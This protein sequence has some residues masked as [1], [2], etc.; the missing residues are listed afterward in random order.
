MTEKDTDKKFDEFVGNSREFFKRHKIAKSLTSLIFKT[1][2][3]I[4]YGADLS[5]P[6]ISAGL[7][8]GSIVG[9]P[10]R[11]PSEDESFIDN[12]KAAGG[13]WVGYDFMVPSTFPK[14]FEAGRIEQLTQGRLMGIILEE[15][16][17]NPA[18]ER[19]PLGAVSISNL[20]HV[21]QFNTY[22]AAELLDLNVLAERSYGKAYETVGLLERYSDELRSRSIIDEPVFQVT[23]KGNG[24]VV[25]IEDFGKPDPKEEL[26]RSIVHIPE[27]RPAIA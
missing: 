24:L 12:M 4:R 19:T 26:E 21:L 6:S 10:L 20:D 25:L 13:S 15:V 27:L 1:I 11:F 17:D 5:D 14:P 18:E 22:T 7:L 8:E 16:K 3:K 2:L 23:P 9:N